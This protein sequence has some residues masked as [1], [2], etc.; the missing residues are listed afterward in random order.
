LFSSSVG[1]AAQCYTRRAR[2]VAC[3]RRCQEVAMKPVVLVAIERLQ[4][5]VRPVCITCVLTLAA[6]LLGGYLS[7]VL[8]GFPMDW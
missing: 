6:V 2:H 7:F 8:R 1:F 3:S 5:V 4:P